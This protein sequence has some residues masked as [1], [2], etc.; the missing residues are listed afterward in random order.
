[1]PDNQMLL[2]VKVGLYVVAGLL[3]VTGMVQIAKGGRRVAKLS[4]VNLG[5]AFTI[6]G[7]AIP[8]GLVA[9]LASSAFFWLAA[10]ESLA[11]AKALPH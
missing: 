11:L 4:D 8:A 6:A 1:M 9:L 5:S 10:N 3:A 2:A 7:G